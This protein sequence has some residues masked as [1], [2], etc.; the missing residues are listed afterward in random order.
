MRVDFVFGVPN[1]FRSSCLLIDKLYQT[2]RHLLVF[3]RDPR[4]LA[5]FD[6]LLWGF[7]PTAFIPH[8]LADD[9]HAKDSP[10]VLC[11][12]PEQLKSAQAQLDQ[13]WLLNLDPEIPPFFPA[14][15][16]ILE[17]VSSEPNCRAQGR[18][19]WRAYQAQGF[20]LRARERSA[21]EPK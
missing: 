14:S 3:H 6:R 12:Q 7:Q 2:D 5:H 21:R 11:S 13:P 8:C 9:P 17:V 16:R 20:Q 19:R 10:I 1:R 18:A 15:Q 4:A